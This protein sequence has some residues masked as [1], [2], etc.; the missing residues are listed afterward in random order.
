MRLL[1][2]AMRGA[3][4]AVALQIFSASQ[5]A[6]HPHVWITT[7]I[8]VLYNQDKAITGFQEKWTFDVMYTAFAIQ[9]LDKN[10]DGKYDRKELQE[11]AKVNI[12]ALKEFQY[13]TYPKIGENVVSKLQP[14]SYWMEHN[15]KQLSLKFKL[16]LDEPIPYNKLGDFSFA[17]YDPTFYI[18]LS[19]AGEKPIRLIA[20]PKGCT[21]NIKAPPPQKV[22]VQSLSESFFQKLSPT[23]DMAAGYANT[24]RI[25]CPAS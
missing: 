10:K 5:A 13:F 21:P 9:G 22:A 4:L 2:L 12:N 7:E 17:V 15:G 24:V 14:E 8:E 1:K 16:N 11:L 19:F 3:A 6:A 20:A 23:S 18:E 25:T